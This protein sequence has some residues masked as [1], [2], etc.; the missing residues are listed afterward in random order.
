MK[1]FSKMLQSHKILGSL[2][3]WVARILE[4]LKNL[5][6]NPYHISLFI[7]LFIYLFILSNRINFIITKLPKL[8]KIRENLQFIMSNYSGYRY[9]LLIDICYRNPMFGK[10][11]LY[12]LQGQSIQSHFLALYLNWTSDLICLKFSGKIYYT[13]KICSLKFQNPLLLFFFFSSQTLKNF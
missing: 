8:I 11:S 4:N 12:S 7:Y 10:C 5:L 9:A 2:V 6:Q 1:S 13:A 3:F